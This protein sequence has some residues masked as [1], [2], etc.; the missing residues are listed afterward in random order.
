MKSTKQFAILWIV[1]LVV[2]ASLTVA[3]NP[4]RYKAP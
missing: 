4:V 1:Q 3:Q 2:T